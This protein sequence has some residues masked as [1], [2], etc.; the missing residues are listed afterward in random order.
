[1]P[2]AIMKSSTRQRKTR[3]TET[4]KARLQAAALRMARRCRRVVQGCLREEEW[5]DCDIEFE[6]IIL[7]EL[8][9]LLKDD[10]GNCDEGR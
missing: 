6:A 7:Q 5:R 1:M 8:R 10:D 9:R 3:I 2:K 4:G